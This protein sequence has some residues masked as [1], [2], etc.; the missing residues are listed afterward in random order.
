MGL[1][2]FDV[3]ADDDAITV[4]LRRFARIMNWRRT[5][6]VERSSI[7]ATTVAE[8]G[9]L[10]PLIDHRW[11]GF[12][13]HDGDRRPGRTRIGTMLGRGVPGKQF[14]AVSAGRPETE[15]LVVDLRTHEF[16]RL[17]VPAPIRTEGA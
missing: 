9:E 15:L 3:V 17:V 10:E 13:T 16:D 7:V 6:V 11:L 4:V 12:G 5:V 2:D 1:T 14:W 8:R